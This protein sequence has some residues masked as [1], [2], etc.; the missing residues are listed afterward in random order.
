MKTLA[1]K[2]N[3][4]IKEVID[5]YNRNFVP[6]REL[7]TDYLAVLS[8]GDELIKA[9]NPWAH[10]MRS[11]DIVHVRGVSAEE[12]VFIHAA[13][14]LRSQLPTDVIR[15]AFYRGT[16]N[17]LSFEMYFVLPQFLGEIETNADV[18]VVNP[19]PDMILKINS[20]C[21]N[22]KYYIEDQ[23]IFLLYKYQFGKKIQNSFSDVKPGSNVLYTSRE[24][25]KEKVIDKITEILATNPNYCKFVIPSSIIDENR[26]DFFRILNN[27][28]F[29][30]SICIIPTS[31][32]NSVSK[33][34]IM[35]NLTVDRKEEI[36]LTKYRDT[37]EILEKEDDVIIKYEDY[38]SS[39]IT[40]NSIYENKGIEICGG[41][42]NAAEIVEYSKEIRVYINIL[43]K[44]HGMISGVGYYKNIKDVESKK[45]GTRIS[46]KIEKGM[47]GDSR[48]EV[49]RK[50]LNI[51]YDVK[52]YDVIVE[53]IYKNYIRVNK[54]VSIKTLFF[55]CINE[56]HDN[57]L[58]D[59]FDGDKFVWLENC[60]VKSISAEVLR[61]RLLETVDNI[62]VA[63][64][65]I[66]QL[67]KLMKVAIRKKL[68]DF[69]PFLT[70]SEISRIRQQQRINSLRRVLVRKHID[71]DKE[72]S[73]IGKSIS[74]DSISVDNSYELSFLLRYF[75]GISI[76][77]LCAIRFKDFKKVGNHKSVMISRVINDDGDETI[78]YEPKINKLRLVPLPDFVSMIIDRRVRWMHNK[79]LKLERILDM[80]LMI[81]DE[82]GLTS[83]NFLRPKI[84][85]KY[86]N[87]RLSQL[88]FAQD[89]IIDPDTGRE[90]DFN[91][92]NGDIVQTNYRYHIL[93]DCGFE[94]NEINHV[95][96]NVQQDTFSIYYCDFN[97]LGSQL[98]MIRKLN[99]WICRIKGIENQLVSCLI[100]NDKDNTVTFDI[101]TI[102]G[103][104]VDIITIP[105]E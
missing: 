91:M 104:E 71:N 16:N 81:D 38:I 34:K 53:D 72:W 15:A 21:N 40:T 65:I 82:K 103:A 87:N 41:K 55:L 37:D 28:I 30:D 97:S 86:N 96:G 94:R 13:M 51:V 93:N 5:I 22:D 102:C 101:N 18:L 70:V 78:N 23:T 36:K 1:I 24:T 27:Q 4:T 7:A 76:K 43:I 54:P 8:N 85:L 31:A 25:S 14:K 12:T 77:E 10:L 74:E 73:L 61:D 11:K 17:D 59:Y 6:M 39:S 88:G 48:E 90:I 35:I 75:T 56:L 68:I 49:I 50:A 62:N 57:S 42:Y 32:T 26:K 67:N 60:Y 29:V 45:Y 79:G 52:L 46:P 33:R 64:T 95:V 83:E 105:K 69:N 66:L 84:F 100:S 20:N 44:R 47:R 92:Y 63:D 2:I 58:I 3:G 89:I 99:R 80:H 98:Q 9:V 19:S